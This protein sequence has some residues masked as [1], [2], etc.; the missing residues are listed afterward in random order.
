MVLNIPVYTATRF[1]V[2]DENNEALR[3]F[4]TKAQAKNF[5]DTDLSLSIKELSQKY[6]TYQVEE[7]P[8]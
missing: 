1:M 2:M 8:F 5:I 4:H 3:G 7:A 6:K